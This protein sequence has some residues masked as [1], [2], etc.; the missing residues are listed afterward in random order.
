MPNRVRYRR[1]YF[2]QRLTFPLQA[3]ISCGLSKI[4]EIIELDYPQR[5]VAQAGL[6]VFC[7]HRTEEVSLREWLV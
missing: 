6:L 2:L 7:H 3:A 1:V 5:V 4:S